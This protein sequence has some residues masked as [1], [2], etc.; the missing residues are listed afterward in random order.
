MTDAPPRLEIRNLTKRISGRKILKGFTFSFVAGTRYLLTGP[1]GSGKTTLLKLLAGLMRPSDGEILYQDRPL[2][3]WGSAYGKMVSLLSHELYMY[4]D[5][6]GL[7]N[8][9]FFARLHGLP[10]P[11]NRALELLERVGLKFFAHEPVKSYS[12]GMKQ[13]LA[14]AK[15]ILH[16]PKI[17]LFDEPFSGLDLR[18]T[19]L[20]QETLQEILPQED[21]IFILATH[22]PDLGWQLADQYLYL[23]RGSLQAS[24]DRTHFIEAKIVDRLRQKIDVGV[25]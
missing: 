15:A 17:L 2:E 20:L 16:R 21:G 25:F 11:R 24:G 4:E 8:L 7:E 5:L 22:N 9:E 19:E 23:E 18:G 14:V 10:H 1:N 12:Q 13:R 6:T 3:D